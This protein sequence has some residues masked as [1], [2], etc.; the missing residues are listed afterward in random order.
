MLEL[1]DF[2][3]QAV[4]QIIE[5]FAAYLRKRPGRVIGTKVSY[6]PYYQALASIT[7][8]GKTVIMAQAVAELLPLLS[9]KPIV[10]WLSKGRVV[11]DQTYAN[12]SAR[13]RHLLADYEDVQLLADFDQS[14][15]DDEALALVYLATVG[16]F[17]QRSK[18]KSSLR[19]FR[20]DIDNAD[21]ST[22][23]ALKKRM[24]V[25]GVRRP[26]LIVYD[27]AH[28][29]TDQQTGLLMELEPDGLLL[30]TATP[31]LPQ[32]I[33]RVTDDLKDD[34]GW[35]DADLTTYVKSADVV[36]AGLVKRQILLG[37]Y[38]AQMPETIDDLLGDM[39][40]ADKAVKLLGR[41]LTPRAIYVCRTNIVEGNALKQDDPKRP[42]AQREAPPILIWNYLVHHKGIDPGTIAV[43]TSALKFDKDHPPPAEFVHFKGGDDDYANFISGNYRHII[44]NLGLQEGWD[45]PECYFAYIDKSMQSNIQVEQI[46]GRALRQPNA[47]H[48]EAEVLNTAHFYVRVDA[49]SIFTEVVKEVAKR[50]AAELPEVEI[51]AYDPKKKNRPV[52][53]SPKDVLE[54]PHV[55][56]DPS[57]ALEPIDD[58]IKHLIDFRGDM[59]DNVRG[60][61]AKALVQQKVGSA[62]EAEVEWVERDHGNAVSARWVFQTAVR[63]Q[64]PLALEVTRSDDPKFDAKVELGSPADE[65]IRKGATDVVKTYLEYVV[66]KQRPHNAYVVGEVMV[67][68]TVA[69]SFKNALHGSY[70]GLNKT[71]ELP[72]AKELD[73]VGVAWCRNPPR[74]GFGIPLLSPGQS[75]VFYPDFLAWKGKHVFALD[76]K[77]EHIL[78]SELG[79]KLLAIEPHP[80]AKT[81]LLVRLISQG[82][83]NDHPQRN[84]GDG[85]TVWT[86]GHGYALKPIHCATL[87]HVVKACLKAT[88]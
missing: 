22:W 31:K 45:D 81:K 61:G 16:T 46:I 86:L 2:Q 27:E 3:H 50:I 8:S 85:F 69:E 70:S 24:T 47:E 28:N 83:W 53:R 25:A 13:Y 33:A 48:L 42:F 34:L 17:N 60:A 10:I 35:T 6:V 88:A 41:S 66:L 82:N 4:D 67:D 15:V 39:A 79:R 38:Q 56:R 54:V 59:S 64:F 72:F 68:P 19:L 77:G 37:G 14:D 1:F 32:A 57:A 63:R 62:E 52:P 18:D 26:L 44:F 75:K 7:A 12:L 58:I 78:E 80:K 51:T 49:K 29:L 30:A 84:S 23:N 9:V 43:Y 65:H 55:Y 20:S 40:E 74:S 87:A 5:R 76:T 21:R 71:L 36:E 73:K 11:V